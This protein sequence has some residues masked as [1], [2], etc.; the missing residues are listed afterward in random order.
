V[1]IPIL[2]YPYYTVPSSTGYLNYALIT[3]NIN[4]ST[5]QP[6]GCS[7]IY[8]SGSNTSSIWGSGDRVRVSRQAPPLYL[9]IK[10]SVTP[11]PS[12]APCI[13]LQAILVVV[14][15][16]LWIVGPLDRWIGGSLCLPSE[17][18]FASS[19]D[20]KLRNLPLISTTCVHRKK[21]GRKSLDKTLIL[22]L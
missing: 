15:S 7:S 12:A 13:K 4:N 22:L 19:R 20:G 16:D 5:C 1:W 21:L 14:E 10:L 3:S 18:A 2:S 6:S 9:Y 17:F 8:F 11:C